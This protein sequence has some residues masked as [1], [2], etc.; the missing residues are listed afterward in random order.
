MFGPN[1][2]M[3]LA[4]IAVVAIFFESVLLLRAEAGV[5]ARQRSH[6]LLLRQK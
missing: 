5:C 1:V 4:G 2:A 6:F 3:A